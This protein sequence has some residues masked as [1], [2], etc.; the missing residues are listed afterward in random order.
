METCRV[1]GIVS[2]VS[3]DRFDPSGAVTDT[4]AAQIIW[5]ALNA[6]MV[7]YVTET[8]T[9]NGQTATKVSRK[10]KLVGGTQTKLTLIRDKFGVDAPPAA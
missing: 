2:G 1:Q 7:E 4:Q 9:I 5:I 3:A 8:V 6:T 10:E